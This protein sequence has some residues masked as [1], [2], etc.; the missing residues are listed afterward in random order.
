MTEELS[1]YN[2]GEQDYSALGIFHVCLV[3]GKFWVHRPCGTECELFVRT[4]RREEITEWIEPGVRA[5]RVRFNTH[6]AVVEAIL[7]GSHELEKR[8]GES[9]PAPQTQTSSRR[10]SGARERI[11]RTVPEHVRSI[12]SFPEDEEDSPQ[13]FGLPGRGRAAES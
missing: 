8:V 1:E 4:V 6:G 12:L 7:N 10:P 9:P 2:E 3:C 13:A 11:E 5:R